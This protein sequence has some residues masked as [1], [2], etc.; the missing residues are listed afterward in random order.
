MSRMEQKH[1]IEFDSYER[2]L[3]INALNHF[4]NGLIAQKRDAAPVDE[5]LLKIIRTKSRPERRRNREAR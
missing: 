1:D 5:V 3:V 4:R 2:G